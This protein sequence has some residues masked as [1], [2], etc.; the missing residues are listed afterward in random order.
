MSFCWFCHEAAQLMLTVEEQ[1]SAFVIG[2]NELSDFDFTWKEISNLKQIHSARE[3]IFMGY[4]RPCMGV[5]DINYRIY[6]KIF[7][8]CEGPR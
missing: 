7:H 5:K 6:L 4:S 3:Y 8:G 2:L 1:F